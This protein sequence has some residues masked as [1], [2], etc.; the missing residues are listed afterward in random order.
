MCSCLRLMTD[1]RV[2]VGHDTKSR[3]RNMEGR[4]R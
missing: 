1:E 3:D 2:G 4:S